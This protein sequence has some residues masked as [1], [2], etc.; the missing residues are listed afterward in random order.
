MW[1]EVGFAR[2]VH[3][4][5]LFNTAMY[6]IRNHMIPTISY[7]GGILLQQGICLLVHHIF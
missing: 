1:L 5:P 3:L 6:S 2:T 7:F 4:F